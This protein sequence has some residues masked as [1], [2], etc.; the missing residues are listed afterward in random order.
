MCLLRSLKKQTICKQVD[1]NSTVTS[2][3]PVTIKNAHI[4]FT[5]NTF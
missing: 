5:I 4:K 3:Q 2:W 1:V